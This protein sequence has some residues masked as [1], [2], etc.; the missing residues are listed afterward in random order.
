VLFTGDVRGRAFDP[1]A[2]V[3]PFIEQFFQKYGDFLGATIDNLKKQ[4]VEEDVE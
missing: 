3:V 2:P 1:E 4:N